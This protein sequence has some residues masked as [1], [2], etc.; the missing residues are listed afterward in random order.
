M[1]L[2]LISVAFFLA[3]ASA[4]PLPQE[5]GDEKPMPVS[6]LHYHFIFLSTYL[7]TYILFFRVRKIVQK[8]IAG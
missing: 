8:G 3:I 2:V 5:N 1:K 4:I 7:L 6:I